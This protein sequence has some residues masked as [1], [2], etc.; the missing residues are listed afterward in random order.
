MKQKITTFS[1]IITAAG[2]SVRFG[3]K[4]KKQFY[5][6]NGYPILFYAINIFYDIQEIS[7]IIISLPEAGF[8]KNQ[9]IIMRTFPKIKKFVIGG[10]DRKKSVY[11]A[12]QIC[13]SND[14]VIIHDGVRPFFPKKDLLKMMSKVIECK[15]IVPGMKVKSTTKLIQNLKIE[16]TLDRENLIEVF[17][18]QIFSI[19]MI[20]KYHTQAKDL[21]QLFTDDASLLEHYQESVNWHEL[22]DPILKITT[23]NDLMYMKFLLNSKLNKTCL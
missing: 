23:K 21:L 19:D 12:L 15:A 9:E 18:P 14:F 6:I 10:N 8:I 22:I 17:T 11:N 7:E 5:I 3:S 20:K 1:C 13:D 16:K 2:S 4:Q